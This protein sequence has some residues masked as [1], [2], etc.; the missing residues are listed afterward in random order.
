MLVRQDPAGELNRRII[1]F[2]RGWRALALRDAGEEAANRVIIDNLAPEA[3]PTDFTAPSDVARELEVL[4]GLTAGWAEA[5]LGLSRYSRAKLTHSRAFFSQTQGGRID[6][7][8]V[9]ARGAPW[10]EV[11]DSRLAAHRE[12]LAAMRRDMLG[13]GFDL[14]A[15]QDYFDKRLAQ[16][17]VIPAIPNSSASRSTPTIPITLRA[18]RNSSLGCW[19]R[20]TGNPL[21]LRR[22]SSSVQNSSCWS[23][24]ATS[25][26]FSKTE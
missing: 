17:A 7:A 19:P 23:V 22:A 3:P 6:R 1:S 14:S 12:R 21:R 11:T 13:Q 25:W 9:T 26:I 10:R 4:L 18:L 5:P 16:D 24:S 15:Q 8:A 20:R 2:Y